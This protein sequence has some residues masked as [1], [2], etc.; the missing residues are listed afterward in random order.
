MNI[1]KKKQVLLEFI[2][3]NK[4][5]PEQGSEEWLKS[6]LETIGGSEIATIIGLNP[7]QTIKKLINQKIG[8]TKFS[9]AAPLWFGNIMEYTLQQYTEIIFNTKIYET[10]SIQYEKSKYIKYSPDGISVIDKKKLHKILKD[11]HYENHINPRSNFDNKHDDYKDELLI[12]FE[13]KNPYMRVLKPNEIP[14]YYKPQ[15]QLGLEVIDICEVSIFIESVFRFCSFNDIIL[16]N[17]K[18]NTRY[19]YDKIRYINK[20]IAYS[21]FSLYYDK[22]NHNQEFN[23]LL[24]NIT[25]FLQ[26]NDIHKYDIS[27]ISEYKIINAIMENIVDHK[28]IKVLYH[29]MYINNKADYSKENKDLYYFDKYNNINKFRSEVIRKKKDLKENKNNI[30]LGCFCYKMFNINIQPVFKSDILNENLLN[31]VE[32]VINIIK[33][34]NNLNDDNEKKILINQ[35]HKN[36]YD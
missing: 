20:P 13:F 10:G 28:D 6:R 25:H 30:Y 4:F 22:N 18:Y 35:A 23:N 2:E 11:E 5:L 15:P 36:N 1:S 9:K 3:L 12:L 7:Y 29:D 21:A 14:I 19:H 8:L 24:G 32:K 26:N 16:Q 27:N 17:N 34:C 33:H 31:K